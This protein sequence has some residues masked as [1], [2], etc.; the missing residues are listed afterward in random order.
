MPSPKSKPK[1]RVES[2]ARAVFEFE[3]IGTQWTIEVLEDIGQTTVKKLESAILARIDQFDHHYSRF[4]ADSLVTQMATK[5]GTYQLPADS[6]AMFN[7]YRQLYTLSE[8]AI[9]PLIGQMIADAGYDASYSFASKPLTQSPVWDDVMHVS[10][11]QLTLSQPALL[12]FGAVG[13]GYLVDIVSQLIK[14][15]G[16]GYYIVDAGGDMRIKSQLPQRVGL[17][18]PDKP[19]EVIGVAA[20]QDGALCGSATNRRQWGKYHHIMD[21]RRMESAQSLQ[22]AWVI[23]PTAMLADGL[24]TALWFLPAERLLQHFS[25]EYALITLNGQLFHSD[26]F[27]AKFYTP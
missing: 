5:A 15:W 7:L 23:A 27:P 20:L 19:R 16:I 1:P 13:K 17:E 10:D 22:A 8:G 3:A 2:P 6:P 24:T 14:S 12:D 9:T 18:H 4:R 26:N 21:P 11:R 25:F